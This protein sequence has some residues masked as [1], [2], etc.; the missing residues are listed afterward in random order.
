MLR[1]VRQ[2]K[3]YYTYL[4]VDTAQ[5]SLIS[6]FTLALINPVAAG[7][8]TVL[9]IG[10][11]LAYGFKEG[12]RPVAEAPQEKAPK[13]KI[14]PLKIIKAVPRIVKATPGIAK[15]IPGVVWGYI[16]G[17]F[18]NPRFVVGSA[19][20]SAGHSFIFQAI[21]GA[22]LVISAGSLPFLAFMPPVLA[23]AGCAAVA[24]IGAVSMLSGS[25]EKWRAVRKYFDANFGT[26]EAGGPEKKE[27]VT[28]LGKFLAKKRVQKA[29]SGLLIGMALETSLFAIGASASVLAAQV[30][31]VIAA[32]HTALAAVPGTLLALKWMGLNVWNIVSSVKMAAADFGRERKAK[33]AARKAEKPPVPPVSSFVDASV[34]NTFD[35]AA[36]SNTP[37]LEENNNAAPKSAA[38]RASRPRAP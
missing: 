34:K 29:R 10:V 9:N 32:P 21:L 36:N 16:K 19:S 15:K 1:R 4:L 7:V 38:P 24:A 27:P 5:A 20:A 11:N 8:V 23:I 30:G 28:R 22:A 33:E 25:A 18:G 13:K 2:N 26:A 3:G 14:S 6:F 12:P 31:G 35:K 37:A 17:T